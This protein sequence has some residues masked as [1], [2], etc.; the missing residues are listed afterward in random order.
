[1]AKPRRHRYKT[2][3]RLPFVFGR[4]PNKDAAESVNMLARFPHR[5]HPADETNA[6]MKPAPSNTVVHHLRANPEDAIGMQTLREAPI[7]TNEMLP[8]K[9]YAPGSSA[10]TC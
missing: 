9:T 2:L 3:S 5:L 6:S 4:W 1:M 10:W 8:L 7:H